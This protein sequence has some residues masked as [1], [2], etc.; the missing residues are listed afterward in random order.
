MC[1][2]RVTFWLLRS[3]W[4]RIGHFS[5]SVTQ[6][7]LFTEGDFLSLSF[8]KSTRENIFFTPC[9]NA[10]FA[11]DFL[12]VGPEIKQLLVQF[13]FS[14]LKWI[15]RAAIIGAKKKYAEEKVEESEWSMMGDSL[16]FSCHL[17]FGWKKYERSIH[18]E[19]QKMYKLTFFQRG[20]MKDHA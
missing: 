1:L 20:V 8:L 14:L 5:A 13:F 16:D 11:V 9:H 4:K 6:R 3:E 2:A 18:F 10:N 17:G 15:L 12:E 7:S 19:L